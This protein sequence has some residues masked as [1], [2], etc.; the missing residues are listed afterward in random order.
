MLNTLLPA[1]GHPNVK[2][3]DHEFAVFRSQVQERV[4]RANKRA[5]DGDADGA[6]PSKKGRK[7][8][9]APKGG[10]QI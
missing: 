1:T 8:G 6:N 4:H 2:M 10:K 7:K 5:L 9:N 3:P